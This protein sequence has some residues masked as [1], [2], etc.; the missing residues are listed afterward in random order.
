MDRHPRGKGKESE[1][2][3]LLALE[4]GLKAHIIGQDE[5]V[6]AVAKAMKRARADLSG[7]RRP[8]SFIFVG[9][10]GWVRPSL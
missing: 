4:E 10:T 6:E 5:A 2:A 3:K 8:A 1:F 9:P 7:K